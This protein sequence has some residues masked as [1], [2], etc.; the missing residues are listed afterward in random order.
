MLIKT[1]ARK[2]D[3]SVVRA[4]S[5]IRA[6]VFHFAFVASVTGMKIATN[7]LYLA[8][9]D[10]KSL[11]WLYLATAVVITLLTSYLGRRL[12][13]QSAKP[14]LRSSLWI[15]A[16]VLLALTIPA[17]L[18]HREGLGV[19]YVAGESYATVLSVL[20]WA[21]LGEVFDV[22]S[23]KR[24][25]GGIA[26]L[27]MAGA[28][29]AG[30]LAKVLA[31]FVPS[32]T[33]CFVAALS[34]FGLM[35]FLGKEEISADVRR[36][37]SSLRDGLKYA[38]SESF[39][40]AVAALVLLLSM[41]TAASDFVFRFGAH[42]F[43]GGREEGLAA[44]FGVL[45]AIVGVLAIAFQL[46]ITAKLLHRLGVFVY[47][48]VVPALCALAAL[49]GLG[50][51]QLFLPLLML[52][53]FEMMGS[54]S[55]HQPGLQLLYNPMP[56]EVRGPVRALIDGA[57]R[58]LG[59]AV[60]GVVLIAVGVFLTAEQLLA[61]VLVVSLSSLAFL[62]RLEPLYLEALEEKLGK[63]EQKIP[64]FDPSER[65]TR[66][67]LVRAL[68]DGDERK[69][70]AA[71]SVLEHDPKFD[72]GRHITKL[73]G[74]PAEAVRAKAVEL[75]SLNPNESFAPYLES[76]IHGDGRKSR[77]A[78][79]RALLIVNKERARAVLDPILER[80]DIERD[81]DVLGAA[82]V[83]ILDPSGAP[84]DP[85]QVAFAERVLE[86]LLDTNHTQTSTARRE[87]VEL[88]G[89]LSG[90]YAARL[91]WFFRDTSPAVREAAIE[92]AGRARDPSLPPKLAELLADRG[93]RRI[94]Q[95]SL[96]AY[97]DDVVPMLQRMLDD[98]RLPT[99]FR[100]QIPRVLRQIATKPAADAMLYSNKDDDPFL[101][102]TITEELSRLRRQHPEIEVDS[103]RVYSA[104]LRRLRASTLYAPM[105]ADVAVGP[106]ELGLLA[107]ALHDRVTKN[108]ETGLQIL[109]LKHGPSRMAIAHRGLVRAD[110]QSVSDAL[111]IVSMAL[112][113]EAA[114]DEIF[115]HLGRERPL[116]VGTRA[117]DRALSLVEGNDKLLARIAEESLKRIGVTPPPVPE[118]TSGE[119]LMSNSIL[120]KVFLLQNV[121]LF[122]ALTVDELTAVAAVT[123]EGHAG[124]REV[125]YAEGTEGNSLYVITSGEIQLL[126]AGKLL[127]TL[128]PGESFGQTSILDG[129][130]RPVTAKCGD[131]GVD[132]V[133]LD[134][135][136]L[137]DL[138]MDRPALLSGLFVELGSRI[139]ELIELSERQGSVA[140]N[141]RLTTG[142]DTERPK[143]E[144]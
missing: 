33:W 98:R 11:P 143:K 10:P 85:K 35:R 80:A 116:A 20:F 115:E 3:I 49:W 106:Q 117:V 69:T 18:D 127:L 39:P 137:I 138:L 7:A 73:I 30:V 45:N 21:R 14:L 52:K 4:R 37:R 71:I 108:L 114:H 129:G 38:A 95:K 26:A 110:P 51:P 40:R 47:L 124:P 87:V 36:E 31:P 28:V 27:G 15:S 132:Y 135:Q 100:S 32:V 53:V 122:R 104:A 16:L 66:R 83:A 103:S 50:E 76:V 67:Q 42:R 93:V 94:T 8:H 75:I 56:P 23:A 2:F 125:V 58:K 89:G 70:L 29:V 41:L 121:Q 13:K 12:G 96:A 25:F 99:A 81:F 131:E 92:A 17:A 107:R 112:S 55:I 60:G 134:R 141:Q 88:L 46:T 90:R 120:D 65:A 105:A 101:M 22:R 123:T 91:A 72:F 144:D 61:I 118:P 78:A 79:A 119:P 109:G 97:G 126:R 139:R 74:H 68:V 86:R 77:A 48:S 59:G 142:A 34:L 84:G 82:I 62:R 44:L 63:R 43:E 57:V 136:D 128:Q 113:G 130:L 140:S 64:A 133:R 6:A 9:R 111:E 102:F 1:V 54:Y 19:L 5:A 24:V